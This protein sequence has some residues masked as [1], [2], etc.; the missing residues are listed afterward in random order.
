M[1]NSNNQFN[2]SRMK[3]CLACLLCFGLWFNGVAAQ[4]RTNT[5]NII[6]F[7]TDD[8]GY[9]DV[10]VFGSPKIKTPHLDQMAADGM[11]FT[12]FYS[13]SPV[14]SPS[15]AA[16]L[17][18]AYPPRVGVPRV[19][20][21]NLEG[22]LSSNEVTIADLLKQKNYTTSCIGKW[23]LGDE[24]KYLP[25]NQGFDFYYGIPFSNDMSANPSAKVSPSIEY[26]ED[27]T[28][29]S[30]REKKWR[31]GKVP[32]FRQDEIVEYP[33]DQTTL[34]QRYTQ[35]AVNF[36][37]ENKE[38]PFFLYLAQ[39]MPHI[40]LYASEKFK[41]KSER[42]L[43][44]DVIEE[45]DWSMGQILKTL[46]NLG[47]EEETLVI[48]TSDNGPWNLENGHG[49]SAYPLRG[50]KFST[51]EGGMREPMIAQWKG[52]IPAGSVCSEV[53]STIDMLPTI[54][55]LTESS[56]PNEIIDGHNIWPLL[57]GKSRKSIYDKKGF[58]YFSDTV[59]QAVRKNQWKLRKTKDELE[60]FNLE[61]DISE[62]K[63]LATSNPKMVKKLSKL[64][65]KFESEW[66]KDSSRYHRP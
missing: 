1:E 44:G 35:E 8:Q 36:I 6:I 13:A 18:G 39:T 28:L 29:D 60:L 20:W 34:T 14:C 5:P 31:A 64:I 47:I 23:H 62:A 25:T 66:K 54:A 53:A 65:E 46:K 52:Q 51:Y 11:R 37:E 32:L 15:R 17:T 12:D 4:E 56:L 10:G 57:N 49:G 43:Y 3:I 30:L 41:G 48:F 2:S 50:Y 61:L 16:L 24:A 27:M 42:G 55:Y 26:R 19:L 9:N 33:V 22:G 40:P 63:N 59:V 7:F 58:F 21:P 38:R 45:L